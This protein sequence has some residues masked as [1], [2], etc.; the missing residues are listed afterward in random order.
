MTITLFSGCLIWM[1]S[2][3]YLD[4]QAKDSMK[5][6]PKRFGHHSDSVLIWTEIADE[7][8]R[9]EL[10]RVN[11]MLTARCYFE[12]NHHAYSRSILWTTRGDRI[13][14]TGQ[15]PSPCRPAI[16]GSPPTTSLTNIPCSCRS[17]ETSTLSSMS[18]S[19]GWD[20]LGW[21]VSG[22]KVRK[23]NHLPIFLLC[24]RR[25][26]LYSTETL[27]NRLYTSPVRC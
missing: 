21:A 16:N 10:D 17:P 23:M 18:H 13:F 1:V 9:K 14:P 19:S 15:C 2:F 20:M 24:F 3:G 7:Q 8:F 11:S 26:K 5:G 6:T 27:L 22:H 12:K 4:A 25:V